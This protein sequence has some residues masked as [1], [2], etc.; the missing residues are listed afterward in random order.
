MKCDKHG[1]DSKWSECWQCDA[2]ENRNN[3]VFPREPWT[4]RED[5]P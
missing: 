5:K 2:E 4:I 1:H 3:Y